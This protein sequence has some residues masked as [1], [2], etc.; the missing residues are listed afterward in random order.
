MKYFLLFLFAL[1][2]A[3][4]YSQVQKVYITKDGKYTAHSEMAVSYM[5]VEIKNDTTY[6]T[7]QYDMY[8]TILTIGTYKDAMLSIPNGEFIYYQ[9]RHNKKKGTKIDINTNSFI[10]AVGNFVNGKRNGKW[11]MYDYGGQKKS[12]VFYINNVLNG[13]YK[14]FY[15]YNDWGEGV[16]VN[17]V[18]QGKYYVYLDSLILSDMVYKDGDIVKD[19]MHFHLSGGNMPVNFDYYMARHLRMYKDIISNTLAPVVEIKTNKMGKVV[20][21]K[22]IRGINPEIDSAIIKVLLASPAFTPATYDTVPI[23][24]KTTCYIYMFNNSR[25]NNQEMEFT[26]GPFKP[27]FPN[28]KETE[29]N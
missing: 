29:G 22:I 20:G 10:K 23:E 21:S 4:S 12:E 1:C 27:I 18:M 3:A 16:M 14:T 11:T 17:G 8:N 9:E 28:N 13:L 15:N 26:K 6:Y 24:L 5:L 25:L 7:K 19:S 2:C